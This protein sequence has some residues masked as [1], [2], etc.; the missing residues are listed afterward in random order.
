[1]K[2]FKFLFVCTILFSCY[3]P[4]NYRLKNSSN[5][6][7]V[8]NFNCKLDTSAVYTFERKVYSSGEYVHYFY[9]HR[10]FGDGR[11]FLSNYQK[12]V[13]TKEDFDDFSKGQKTYYTFT[14]NK[15]LKLESYMN[16]KDGYYL[17]FGK[18]LKDS[19]LFYG[20]RPRSP[21]SPKAEMESLGTKVKLIGSKVKADW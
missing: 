5:D 18:V 19:I 12:E 7:F 17:F 9:F 2:I 11:V 20:Y 3:P 4:G 21:L 6:K 8:E 1:M 15:D 10:Y 14:K 16:S 13:F